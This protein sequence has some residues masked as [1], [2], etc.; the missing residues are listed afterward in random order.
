MKGT[1]AVA[2]AVSV[3][4]VSAFAHGGNRGPN[5]YDSNFHRQVVQQEIRRSLRS[6]E[7]ARHAQHDEDAHQKAGSSFYEGT[8]NPAPATAEAVSAGD[9]AEKPTANLYSAETAGNKTTEVAAPETNPQE[10]EKGFFAKAGDKIGG[11]FSTVGGF[12]KGK[13]AMT[14]GAVAGGLIGLAFGGPFGMLLG[15]FIGGFGGWWVGDGLGL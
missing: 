6:S 10:G 2:A 7:E 1:I 8:W 14:G 11:F 13:L 4:S 9:Y 3:L 12:F 15:A 5:P